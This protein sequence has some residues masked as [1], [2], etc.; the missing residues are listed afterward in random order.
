[1]KARFRTRWPGSLGYTFTEDFPMLCRRSLL[2]RGACLALP[3][4]L[5]TFTPAAARADEA[6]GTPRKVYVTVTERGGKPVTDMTAADFEV[7]EDGRI[8]EINVRLATDPVRVALIVADRGTGM[9]QGASLRFVEGMLGHGEFAIT[10]VLTQPELAVDFTSDTDKLRD[11]LI[12]IGRRG[13]SRIGAQVVEAIVETIP[14]LPREGYRP[15]I[16]VLRSGGEA[17]TS[18]RSERVRD[19]LRQHGIMLYAVSTTGTQA[20]GGG[21]SPTS[22]QTAAGVSRANV[23]SELMEGAMTLGSIL[24]DGA[25]DTGGRHEQNIATTLIPTLQQIALE[26]LNQYEITYTLPAGVSP[27]DRISVSSKRRGVQLQAPTRIAN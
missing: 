26:L 22:A 19:D 11:G 12:A 3:V 7:K 1:M 13:A 20:M 15:V 14:R 25:K 2:L 17:P 6:Q 21:A 16:V 8:Q 9:F 4:G 23:E 18:L 24:G 5:L 27:H 10:G